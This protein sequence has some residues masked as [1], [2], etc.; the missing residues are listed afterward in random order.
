MRFSP[1][2][3]TL[4]VEPITEKVSDLVPEELRERAP[5]T[6]CKLL[7]KATDCEKL[8]FP[9]ALVVVRT[10]G[11]EEI[12]FRGEI[13]TIVSEKFVVGEIDDGEVGRDDTV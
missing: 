7:V 9:K 1:T 5:F 4:L 10:E 2:N 13:F 12:K 6:A 3:K 11:L 8:Y